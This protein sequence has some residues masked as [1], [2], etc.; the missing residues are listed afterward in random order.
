MLGDITTME[1]F[2][3][4]TYLANR[5]EMK[6]LEAFVRDTSGM[7]ELLFQFDL[8]PEHAKRLARLD[9]L[10]EERESDP[11]HKLAMA[12]ECYEAGQVFIPYITTLLASCAGLQ[13]IQIKAVSRIIDLCAD[14][15]VYRQ[16][17]VGLQNAMCT[18]AA[19]ANPMSSFRDEFQ[20]MGGLACVGLCYL[21]DQEEERRNIFEQCLRNV[22]PREL[23]VNFNEKTMLGLCEKFIANCFDLDT[24]D[25]DGI[26]PEFF[27]NMFDTTV[28][29]ENFRAWSDLCFYRKDCPSAFLKFICFRIDE[30]KKTY[31]FGWRRDIGLLFARAWC[32][33]EDLRRRY[34]WYTYPETRRVVWRKSQSAAVSASPIF[35]MTVTDCC[36]SLFFRK[37]SKRQ[38]KPKK[39]WERKR[40]T[41][42][43]FV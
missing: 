39:I 4:M 28:F 37:R 18:L 20:K 33:D 15:V 41:G 34:Q 8:R 43:R 1:I 32:D 38:R 6:D 12:E 10:G 26:V 9:F 23:K 25:K 36:F 21:E 11:E 7:V 13:S 5:V 14:D 30:V 31:P 19:M 29:Q 17:P 27:A 16:C 35:C 42:T 3:E 2:H 22:K 40:L 24:E